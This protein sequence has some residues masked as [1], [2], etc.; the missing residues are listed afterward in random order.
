MTSDEFKPSA[1]AQA[2]QDRRDIQRI[3]KIVLDSPLRNGDVCDV[4]G[5]QGVM[6]FADKNTTVATRMILSMALAACNGD[7]KSAE[8][9]MKYGGYEPPKEQQISVDLPQFIDDISMDISME[10][11]EAMQ[12]ESEEQ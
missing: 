7:H 8:F 3:I 11:V 9:L 5:T 1:K 4:D 6:T 10:D 2:Q 12:A